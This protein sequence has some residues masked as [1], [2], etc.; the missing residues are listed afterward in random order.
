LIIAEPGPDSGESI[1]Q[2]PVGHG[3]FGTCR[4][5]RRP[6]VVAFC[7]AGLH[8]IHLHKKTLRPCSQRRPQ[9][10]SARPYSLAREKNAGSSQK[11]K[12]PCPTNWGVPPRRGTPSAQHQELVASTG[13]CRRPHGSS[14]AKPTPAGVIGRPQPSHLRPHCVGLR[15]P[16][17]SA[18]SPP[19]VPGRSPPKN[20]TGRNRPGFPHPTSREF[21]LPTPTLLS[22]TQATQ[23]CQVPIHH[24]VTISLEIAAQCR[25][26]GAWDCN[27]AALVRSPGC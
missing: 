20:S 24:Y 25:P 21:W 18:W 27:R 17:V 16:N 5:F 8:A 15:M 23:V 4:T 6:A 9:Q 2:R 1:D 11:P 3:S 19:G 26:S 12:P 10:E 7:Q 13:R 14:L 22:L